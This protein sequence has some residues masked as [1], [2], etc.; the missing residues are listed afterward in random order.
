MIATRPEKSRGQFFGGWRQGQ[1]VEFE[2]PV[3]EVE[4]IALTQPLDR[5]EGIENP[6]RHQVTSRRDFAVHARR[7]GVRTSGDATQAGHEDDA[8][9]G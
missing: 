9:Q 1:F 5:T 7:A 4:H 6:G 2:R 8:R 3:F